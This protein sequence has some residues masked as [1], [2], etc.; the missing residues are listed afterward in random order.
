MNVLFYRLGIKMVVDRE[1]G[2]RYNIYSVYTP[3]I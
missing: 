1:Y 2:K 3:V